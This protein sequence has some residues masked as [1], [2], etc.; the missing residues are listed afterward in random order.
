VEFDMMQG[1]EVIG[2]LGKLVAQGE[3]R[4]ELYKLQVQMENLYYQWVM[5]QVVGAQKWLL[6]GAEAIS[7]WWTTA[8]SSILDQVKAGI[9]EKFGL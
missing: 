6:A 7:S 8:Q 3:Q 9:S 2:L 1:Q 5:E 4:Y